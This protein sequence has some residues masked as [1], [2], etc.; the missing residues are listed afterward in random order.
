[1]FYRIEADMVWLTIKAQPNASQSEIVGLYD[2]ETLKIRIK[3]PAVEGAANEELIRLLSKRF[4]VS[5]SQIVFKTGH[6]S[7]LKRVG[8]PYTDAFESFAQE[9]DAGAKT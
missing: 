6:N 4:K 8:L 2:D 5:K 1:M 3:A 7:K 9:M